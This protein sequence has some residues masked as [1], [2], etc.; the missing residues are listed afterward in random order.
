M[1]TGVNVDLWLLFNGAYT[2]ALSIPI[3]RCTELS[4][5]PLEW[6]RF[7]GYAI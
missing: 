4:V 7:F 5:N 6:L 2:R 1:A 3:E